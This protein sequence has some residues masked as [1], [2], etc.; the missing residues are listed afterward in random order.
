MFQFYNLAQVASKYLWSVEEFWDVS[1][2]NNGMNILPGHSKALK[3][4]PHS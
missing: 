4:F 2:L 3:K 1:K